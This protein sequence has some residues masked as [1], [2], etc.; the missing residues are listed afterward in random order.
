MIGDASDDPM[1]FG[2]TSVWQSSVWLQNSPVDFESE[3]KIVR[4][5]PLLCP[6]APVHF[7][8]YMVAGRMQYAV[9]L[10]N[11]KLPQRQGVAGTTVGLRVY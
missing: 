5:L 7:T 1:Q 4:H 2:L 8:H 3:G 9:R 10:E 6:G 11:F